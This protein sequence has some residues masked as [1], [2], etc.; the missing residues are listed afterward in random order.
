MVGAKI[1]KSGTLKKGEDSKVLRDIEFAFVQLE[2]QQG[3]EA[4]QP[5]GLPM[6]FLKTNAGWR[7]SPRQ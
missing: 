3:A 7:F 4:A 1:V 5:R 6:I 2:I